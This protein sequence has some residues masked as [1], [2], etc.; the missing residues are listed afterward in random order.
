MWEQQTEFIRNALHTFKFILSCDTLQMNHDKQV[1]ILQLNHEEQLSL[2]ASLN[3]DCLDNRDDMLAV[4]KGHLES[5]GSFTREALFVRS[6][7]RLPWHYMVALWGVD[8]IKELYTPE[9]AD[10]I[11]PKERR[12][13]FDFALT[14]L[15]GEPLPLARWGHEY[16]KSQRNK[17]FSDRGN[18][19]KPGVL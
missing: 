10:R 19:P 15:R 2:T 4:I 1:I 12:R 6:L 3:W 14:I 8:V 18:R 7:E 17:F 13:H 11:W 9:I 16:Y 5:S